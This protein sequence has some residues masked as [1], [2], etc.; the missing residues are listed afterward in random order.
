MKK[1]ISNEHATVDMKPY[2]SEEFFNNYKT[3]HPEL[4]A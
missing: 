3:S 1:V 2:N 4:L